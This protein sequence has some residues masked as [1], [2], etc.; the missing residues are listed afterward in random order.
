MEQLDATAIPQPQME[1]A[2]RDLKGVYAVATGATGPALPVSPPS[3]FATILL[4]LFLT[5]VAWIIAELSNYVEIQQNWATY[6]CS[7]SVMPFSRFYGHDLSETMRFCTSEAVREHAPGVIDPIYQGINKV[8]GVVEGVY[9]RVEDVA[10]GITDLLSGFEKFVVGFFNSFRLIGTRV[11]MTFIRMKGIFDRVYGVFLAFSFAAISAITFGQNMVC[12]PLVTFMGE[13]TGVDTCCFAPDT[14]IRMADGTTKAIQHARIGDLLFGKIEVSG[15]FEFDG[16]DVPM[17][18]LQKDVCVS[19]NHCVLLDGRWIQAG[20]HPSA[21]PSAISY[22]RIYC[23]NVKKGN[24]FCVEGMWFTDYEETD[25]E[26]V[27]AESKRIAE[28]MLNGHSYKADSHSIIPG[29]TLGFDSN[30]KVAM[31]DGSW[32]P[33]DKIKIGDRLQDSDEVMGVVVE[34][35]DASTTCCVPSSKHHR[36]RVGSSQMVWSGREWIRVGN[37]LPIETSEDGHLLLYHL[38][39]RDN[40][41]FRVGCDNYSFIVRDY[42]EVS[43]AQQPFDN[44]LI[45]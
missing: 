5:V 40:I 6:R 10:G 21:K 36:V 18:N 33:I 11:R 45:R 42:V 16:T 34:R 41:P 25:T 27:I 19:A 39:V 32:K 12:N 17:V 35:V 8:T 30:M 23:L 4:A 14:P 43:E 13:I 7:P 28:Q 2:I 20:N 9:D 1:T 37:R 24:R 22:P 44:Y 31:E 3:T 15:L 38:F 26:S 29:Y